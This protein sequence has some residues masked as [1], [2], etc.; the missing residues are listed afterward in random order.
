MAAIELLRNVLTVRLRLAS[1]VQNI[2][3]FTGDARAGLSSAM[4]QYSTTIN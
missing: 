3:V 1:M 2:S 4:Q